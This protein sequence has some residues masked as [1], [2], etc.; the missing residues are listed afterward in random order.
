MSFQIFS[1]RDPRW[2]RHA[3]GSG[4]GELGPYGCFETCFTMVAYDAY[5]DMKW[6][7]DVMDDK[8]WASGVFHGTDL[9]PDNA[10]DQAF[11]GRFASHTEYG[12]NQ[13]HINAAV[14]S[15][16]TYAIVCMHDA[17]VGVPGYHF[18]V[19]YSPST[20]ADPWWGRVMGDSGWGLPNSAVK[21]IFI[22]SLRA[23]L[24][25]QQAA[26][27]AAAAKAA[28]A[29][30]ALQ[31]AQEAAAAAAA[32]A[33][34]AEEAAAEKAAQDAAAQAAADAREAAAHA[35]ADASARAQLAAK[36]LTKQAPTPDF[37]AWLQVV[38]L[39]LAGRG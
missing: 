35:A 37:W 34:A 29:A 25:A 24:E 2:A 27:A 32:A 15:A 39:A 23:Q 9:L 5:P 38:I 13:A 4:A 14:A 19:I 12:W 3:L 31:Q 6:T 18:M 17:A 20:V 16:D 36:P 8:L 11:P 28:A 7:P 26:A 21:V 30:A 10:L 33:K 22:K 1:Q